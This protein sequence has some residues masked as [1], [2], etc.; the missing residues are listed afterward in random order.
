MASHGRRLDGAFLHH[1]PMFF[2]GSL[3]CGHRVPAVFTYKMHDLRSVKRTALTVR[4][5]VPTTTN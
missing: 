1:V 4:V 5:P 2:G 3:H